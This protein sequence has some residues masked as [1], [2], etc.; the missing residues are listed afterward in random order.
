[1][2]TTRSLMI[3]LGLFLM[4]L[5]AFGQATGAL[6][7]RVTADGAALRGV[8]VT[9]TSPALAA[10]RTTT[11]GPAGNYGFS[12]LPAGEYTV[13]FT[14]QGLQTVTRRVTIGAGETT[15][16][17]A[18]LQVAE[19][20]QYVDEVTVTGSLIP[21]PTLEAMSP[22]T[23]LDVEEINYRGTTR[24][25]DLLMSLPQVFAAQNSTI[26]NGASGTA[27]VDLRFLG[28]DRTLVLIDGR[29]MSSGDAFATAA[30]LNFIPAAL[31]KRVDILTGGAS[32]VYGADAVAGV[33]NF[34]LDTD[35]EGVRVSLSGGSFQHDNNNQ[36]AQAMNTKRGFDV[37]SGSSWDGGIINASVAL[38]G[39]FGDGEKGHASGYIDYREAQAML[40][41]TRDYTNCAGGLGANG[42]VCGGSGTWQHGAFLVYDED[43]N[44]AGSWVLDPDGPGNTFR[45]RVSSKDV[46]NYAPLN[47]MQRPDEKLSAGAFVNYEWN[48]HFRGYV[49][50][51]LMDDYTDAQIAPSGD[52]GNTSYINCDN[53]MLTA[54]QR[55]ALCTNAGWG[56]TDIANVVILRRNVEGGGRVSQIR[57]DA[58]R[59]VTGLKGELNDAWS[60]DVYGLN[61]EVHSPQTYA[62]ELNSFRLQEALFVQG[63]PNDPST[64]QCMSAQARSE[65]CVPWN[66]FRMGGVTQEALDYLALPLILNSGTKTRMASGRVTGDLRQYG[67]AFPRAAE[68]IRIA[69]GAEY[70]DEFLFVNPDLAYRQGI[71]A[72]QGGPTLPVEGSFN[73]REVFTEALIPILQGVRGAKDLS[74][75]LGYRFSDYSTSGGHDTYKAQASWAPNDT[76]K[77]RAGLNR[78]TRAPN[79]QELFVPQGLG[80]GGSEDICAGPN[81]TATP[82]Q[83]ARTGVPTSRYGTILENPAGQYNTL[84]GG[85]PDLEPEIADTITLGIVFT[86]PAIS[87]LIAAFDYYDIQIE[88][89]IGA[90]GADDIVATCAETG[91][92]ALCSLIHRD[93]AGTLWL[94]PSGYTV[95]TQQNVGELGAEGIDANIS[96]VRPLGG[97]SLSLNMIGTYNME[98]SINTG[99]YSYDCLGFFGNQCANPS[100]DWRHMARAS[101]QTGPA[102]WSLGWRMVGAVDN[103]DLSD[104]PAIGNAGNV[105][106]LEVNDIATIGAQNYF[107]LAASYNVM[108]G[109]QFT[110]GVNNVF[111]QEPPLAPG[112]QDNDYGTGFYGTYDPNGRYVHASIGFEF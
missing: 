60:Y 38:G 34:I 59:L 22:V 2:K 109:V 10:P 45:P 30:D 77:M 12:G 67:M 65:G 103:D 104:N 88:K 4:A 66:I 72:G 94:M 15:T 7:G 5:T 70:R 81:P 9:L 87:G 49:E 53:P 112:M 48:R 21:R 83:C 62:N 58:F 11:S 76:M 44:G 85:N 61:A 46:Y 51:M 18:D 80:L 50:A 56:P 84:G 64:W 97:N 16:A 39:K 73:L 95:T 75:E 74:L 28:T 35:F 27:T 8:T 99:L 91:N 111:D 92:P 63:D 33:V 78:A 43:W 82:E 89:T 1:M 106:L 47:F 79:V 102:V 26:A 100:P 68:G 90:L 101:L 42:P 19:G 13:T 40:K 32:S 6:N 41:S 23:T 54:Q 3:A 108:K 31:V 107:D 52:F 25:E 36:V 110:V 55:D 98:T 69:L 24:I 96:Y 57:H 17:S 14:L 71:G 29:R 20:Q 105:A 93:V 86:P 37:P